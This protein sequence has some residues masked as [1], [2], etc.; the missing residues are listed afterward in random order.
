[1]P[2]L[3]SE[4]VA[5]L[6]RASLA[7]TA[8]VSRAWKVTSERVLYGAVKVDAREYQWEHELPRLRALLATL[9]GRPD[10][11]RRIARLELHAD[12]Q[13]F[14]HHY[15]EG[16]FLHMATRLMVQCSGLAQLKL[17]GKSLA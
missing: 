12:G 4:I 3:L 10:L 17:E 5:L 8:L 14:Q 11:A 16:H 6:D 2:E 7:Q 1:M 9:A 15:R 13:E